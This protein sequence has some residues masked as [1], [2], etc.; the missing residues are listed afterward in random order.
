MTNQPEFWPSKF[1]DNIANYFA[2]IIL[3]GATK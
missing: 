1:L 2:L 3:D